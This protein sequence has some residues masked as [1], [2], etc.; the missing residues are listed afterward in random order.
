M[1]SNTIEKP[2]KINTLQEILDFKWTTT[3]YTKLAA[4]YTCV[5]KM[6]EFHIEKMSKKM[7]VVYIIW[8]G[9]NS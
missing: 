4:E 5:Y 3:M 9:S 2:N 1:H 8:L 7:W 6:I